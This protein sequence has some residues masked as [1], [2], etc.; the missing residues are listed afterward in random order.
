MS[1][2]IVI[3]A[4][5]VNKKGNNLSLS[6]PIVVVLKMLYVFRSLTNT[7]VNFRLDFII[8]ANNMNRYENSLSLVFIIYL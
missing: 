6:L 5:N 7:Q 2:C 3:P 4:V 8:E 1:E